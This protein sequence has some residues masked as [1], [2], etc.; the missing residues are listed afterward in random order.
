MKHFLLSLLLSLGIV[1]LNAQINDL[2]SVPNSPVDVSVF[3]ENVLYVSNKEALYRV[4]LTAENV[5]AEKYQ[6]FNLDRGRKQIAI[7]GDQLYVTEGNNTIGFATENGLDSG[8][9]PLPARYVF[10][11]AFQQPFGL[12]FDVDTLYIG[13]QGN[14][15][16]LKSNIKSSESRD[17]PDVVATGLSDPSFL[18]INGDSLYISE[19]NKVS[20][21]NIRAAVPTTTDVLTGLTSPRGLAFSGDYLYVAVDTTTATSGKIIRYNPSTPSVAAEDVVTGL[22]KPE[23]IAF[24]GNSL[25]IV[26]RGAN[27]ISSF[28]VSTLSSPNTP[29]IKTGITIFPNPASE[30]LIV[31]G[32]TQETDYE[33]YSLLGGQVSDGSIDNHGRIEVKDLASG[34]YILKIDDT[35][36][37]PFV[38]D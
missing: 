5:T 38:K 18:R 17:N 15:R 7:S 1:S 20:N 6:S 3:N 8:V 32:L 16:I 27:K 21:L 26:E 33:I 10:F 4:D 19:R 12:A 23:G 35:E 13:E 31:N 25:Y 22:N 28:D 14:N 24:N 11:I 34:E 29:S 2:V 37:I 30:K 9:T 36:D